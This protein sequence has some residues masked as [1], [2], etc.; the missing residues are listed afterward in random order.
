MKEHHCGKCNKIYA[1][2][3]S[4]WNHKQ[5]CKGNVSTPWNDTNNVRS[6][7]IPTPQSMWWR[8]VVPPPD[9]KTNSN[10]ENKLLSL[11][12]LAG[13]IDDCIDK[14]VMKMKDDIW[15]KIVEHHG[16]GEKGGSLGLEDEESK[17]KDDKEE[18]EVDRA[19]ETGEHDIKEEVFRDVIIKDKNKLEKMI[20]DLQESKFSEQAGEIKDLCHQY[21]TDG[22]LKLYYQVRGNYYAEGYEAIVEKIFNKLRALERGFTG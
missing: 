1:S 3:Q 5:R 19:E 15:N 9:L 7:V 18:K 20:N 10:E 22:E 4:L 6:Q 2:P 16:L 8:S 12:V 11:E 13:D 17:E 14:R 21:L